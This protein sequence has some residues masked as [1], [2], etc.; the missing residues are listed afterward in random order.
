[1]KWRN[2]RANAG[3]ELLPTHSPQSLKDI[4][5]NTDCQT[6]LLTERGLKSELHGN[7]AFTSNDQQCS[8]DMH[9]RD[10]TSNTIIFALDGKGIEHHHQTVHQ[11]SSSKLVVEDPTLD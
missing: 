5:F 7:S 1:M 6:P 11:T 10:L 9:P 8:P 4:L 3:F 2:T